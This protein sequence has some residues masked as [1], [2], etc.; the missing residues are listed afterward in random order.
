[1]ATR[2]EF[3]EV[4]FFFLRLKSITRKVYEPSTESCFG[5]F[6]ESMEGRWVR[7]L[8]TWLV[9]G[10]ATVVKRTS[11]MLPEGANPEV[12]KGSIPPSS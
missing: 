2:V 7:N 1:M 11:T 3:L 12:E 9:G 8:A 10:E 4:F 6:C 5:L